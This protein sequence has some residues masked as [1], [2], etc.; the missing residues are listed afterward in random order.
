MMIGNK[1]IDSVERAAIDPATPRPISKGRQRSP[2]SFENEP[3]PRRRETI[4]HATIIGTHKATSV[5]T[6]SVERPPGLPW[7]RSCDSTKYDSPTA[8]AKP[9]RATPIVGSPG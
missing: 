9:E 6:N 4:Q 7:E 3:S 5:R 8:T 2:K 1:A